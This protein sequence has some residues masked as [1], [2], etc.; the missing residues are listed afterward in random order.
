[1]EI[2]TGLTK[3]ISGHKVPKNVTFIRI[4]MMLE[5]A[6]YFCGHFIY[7][8]R[9]MFL[10]LSYCVDI[11]GYFWAQ[12]YLFYSHTVLNNTY[13]NKDDVRMY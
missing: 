7:S 1:M 13:M 2:R 12:K 10:F 6:N 4:K 8:L 9:D 3:V 11:F 5:C